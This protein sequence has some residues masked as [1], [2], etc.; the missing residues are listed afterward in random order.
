MPARKI[1]AVDTGSGFAADLLRS[2]GVASTTTP[3][4]LVLTLLGTDGVEPAW[5]S[6][7]TSKGHLA[8]PLV[9]SEFVEGRLFR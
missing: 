3:G 9:N 7:T 4:T 1:L 8:I 6:R 2:S 5:R